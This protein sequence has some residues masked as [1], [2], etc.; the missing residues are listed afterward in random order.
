MTGERV[1]TDTVFTESFPLAD[2][3]GDTVYLEPSFHRITAETAE[4]PIR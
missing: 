2:F 4:I 3:Q 1:D